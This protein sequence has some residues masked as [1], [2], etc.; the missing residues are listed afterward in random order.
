VADVLLAAGFEP[1]EHLCLLEHAMADL[2]DGR[3]LPRTRRARRSDREAVLAV[4][5]R[6][7]GPS[8][9]F[10]GAALDGALQATPVARF[11]VA[12]AGR[13]VVAYAVTGRTRRTGYLQRLAVEPDTWRQRLGRALVVDALSWLARHRVQRAVVNTQLDNVA[14]LALYRSCG[15]IPTRDGLVVLG[16]AL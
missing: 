5:A 11:R 8:W 7:F 1:R 3:G 15:F 9:C 6:A 10:D 14:A 2:P 12:G 13:P 4:D 16:R